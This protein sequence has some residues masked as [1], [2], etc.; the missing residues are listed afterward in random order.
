M[1][2]DWEFQEVIGLEPELLCMVPKSTIALVLAYDYTSSESV[3]AVKKPIPEVDY[4]MW[5]TSKL[6]NACGLIA[7]IH[8]VFNNLKI[9]PIAPESP[10]KNLWDK[11]SK[12]TPEKRADILDNFTSIKE[13]HK[14]CSSEGQ[15]HFV[16][17]SDDVRYHFIC[18]T[19]NPKT[20]LVELDGIARQPILLNGI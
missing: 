1:S 20:E 14:V 2:K 8:A 11:T 9:V 10:L 18:F 6:D 12:E 7:C 4:Y 15:S 19:K 13:A 16:E 17:E 5:Q 3:E